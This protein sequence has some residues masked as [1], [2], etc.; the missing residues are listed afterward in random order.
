MLCSIS[1]CMP[2]DLPLVQGLSA[3]NRV[4]LANEADFNHVEDFDVC[5]A[6]NVEFYKHKNVSPTP[7]QYE[8]VIHNENCETMRSSSVETLADNQ[9]FD[10]RIVDESLAIECV[11]SMSH[12]KTLHNSVEFKACSFDWFNQKQYKYNSK[13]NSIHLFSYTNSQYNSDVKNVERVDIGCGCR[14]DAQG[15][16]HLECEACGMNYYSKFDGNAFIPNELGEYLD[17]DERYIMYTSSQPKEWL[18]AMLPNKDCIRTNDGKTTFACRTLTSDN[19]F[20]SEEEPRYGAHVCTDQET[21]DDYDGPAAFYYSSECWPE[22]VRHRPGQDRIVLKHF[23]GE[24]CDGDG[25]V[26]STVA[27]GFKT[28]DITKR[29]TH[30]LCS[31]RDPESDGYIFVFTGT[32]EG[33][34][35]GSAELDD[36]RSAKTP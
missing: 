13:T 1:E 10:E 32:R 5:I 3:S 18:T 35:V 17:E 20:T 31:S 2:L 21:C 22:E 23:S 8:K 15:N 25:E 11:E 33:V 29:A 16:H 26:L 6:F 19:E 28:D 7:T 36:G 9:Y 34:P 27:C 4:L 12:C 30:T 14:N 24:T